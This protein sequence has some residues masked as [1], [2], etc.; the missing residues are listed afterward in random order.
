MNN[1]LWKS[2]PLN[3]KC[4]TAQVGIVGSHKN[5]DG[6]AYRRRESPRKRHERERGKASVLESN[7]RGA[8]VR[9]YSLSLD[10]VR[11]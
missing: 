10:T 5:E 9:N 4:T 1:K 6:K 7:H 3:N 11:V 2:S 8:S